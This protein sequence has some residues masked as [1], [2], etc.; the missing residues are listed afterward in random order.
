LHIFC[1]APCVRV[2]GGGVR[3]GGASLLGAP[4]YE[5]LGPDEVKQA[6]AEASQSGL[7]T[8]VST[9]SFNAE[10][11]P[12]ASP[13]SA[14]KLSQSQC[15][16][17]SEFSGIKCAPAR[18][19]DA[20]RRE[21]EFVKLTLEA[22]SEAER[23]ETEN[24]QLALK[25]QRE[26]VDRARNGRRKKV[27]DADARGA[28]IPTAAGDGGARADVGCAS[29]TMSNTA[30][31]GEESTHNGSVSDA[32]H[33][34]ATDQR[35][36]VA[37]EDFTSQLKRE[38]SD[39]V[40]FELKHELL[41]QVRLELKQELLSQVRLECVQ[42]LKREVF[43][44]L[45]TRPAHVRADVDEEEPGQE[46]PSA[47][48]S[49]R[50]SQSGTRRP[51]LI[52]GSRARVADAGRKRFGIP[53][54]KKVFKMQA[55]LRYGWRSQRHSEYNRADLHNMYSYAIEECIHKEL[56]AATLTQ[57]G[58][59]VGLGVVQI[60]FAYAFFDASRLLRRQN[61]FPSNRE[62]M[63]VS[64]MYPLSLVGGVKKLPFINWLASLASL[65]LLAMVM[66]HDTDGA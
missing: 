26:R 43:D 56:S 8:M 5:M 7:A 21:A 1:P 28:V 16:R 63:D 37:V 53:F 46:A 51:S 58:F 45:N 66:K 11:K 22:S 15:S 13:A 59:L 27:R 39:Q 57:L 33:E 49:A 32:G 12:P 61:T 23:R 18:D 40:Y 44:E 42:Q 34:A 14:Q 35:T 17:L 29:S 62:K 55:S 4:H 25:L 19:A 48:D 38:L 3:Q 41:E 52:D 36:M 50:P 20:V 54:M 64:L 10:R 47:R 9:W 31:A 24:V 30:E 2:S 65:M 6:G 60:I